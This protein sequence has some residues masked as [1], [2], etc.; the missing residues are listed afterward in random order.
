LEEV[1]Q[2]LKYMKVPPKA[3]TMPDTQKEL[4]ISPA[5][6]IALDHS[7]RKQQRSRSVINS[8]ECAVMSSGRQI[9][10]FKKSIEFNKWKI[11][12]G[13]NGVVQEIKEEDAPTVVDNDELYAVILIDAEGKILQEMK[14]LN[15]EKDVA[16]DLKNKI[17]F[18]GDFGQS[19]FSFG[20]FLPGRDRSAHHFHTLLYMKGIGCKT[21]DNFILYGK[22]TIDA[23]SKYV[24]GHM[25][26]CFLGG[27]WE[28]IN[29]ICGL[30]GCSS[31]YSCPFCTQRMTPENENEE[32]VE[33]IKIADVNLSAPLRRNRKLETHLAD[34]TSLERIFQQQYRG[35][36]TSIQWEKFRKTINIRKMIAKSFSAIQVPVFPGLFTY[37][38]PTPLHVIL[39]L[40]N[41]F[42]KRLY[43]ALDG[44]NQEIFM[45]KTKGYKHRPEG[46][47]KGEKPSAFND[48][49]RWN[50][51][52]EKEGRKQFLIGSR[53]VN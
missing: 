42:L 3:V 36:G 12:M 22:H 53:I 17:I 48:V 47:S 14:L 6:A 19:V 9:N 11:V 52:K 8:S 23:V 41:D 7:W 30:M 43:P 20:F 5:K 40:G 33:E 26:D 35:G 18:M 45:K 49:R 25:G 37:I 15:E 10:N 13:L 21:R 27:D 38:I 16:N 24:D 32:D 29:M 4:I 2:L 51:N 1:D 34:V 46:V 44:T 28:W 31:L 39:G 50:G